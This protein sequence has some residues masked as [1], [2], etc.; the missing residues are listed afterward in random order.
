MF[1]AGI[2]PGFPHC[3]VPK[4]VEYIRPA[5]PILL[6]ICGRRLYYADDFVHIVAI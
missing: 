5:Q 1:L 6:E 4:S 3:K 2:L